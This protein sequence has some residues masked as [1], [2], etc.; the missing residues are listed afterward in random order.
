MRLFAYTFKK[1]LCANI[2]TA[3]SNSCRNPII[4]WV[5]AERRE[6]AFLTLIPSPGSS[7]NTVSL[8]HC[9][10]KG[11]IV[12]V[13]LPQQHGPEHRHPRVLNAQDHWEPLKADHC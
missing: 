7:V 8:P 11:K 2:V 4:S 3:I 10:Q 13:L 9:Y 12:R 1:Q 5:S 6:G